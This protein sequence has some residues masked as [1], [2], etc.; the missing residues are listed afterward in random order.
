MRFAWQK[1]QANHV[2]TVNVA[3]TTHLF[4]LVYNLTWLLPIVLTYT[5][6]I[7]YP[8]GFATFAGICFI[9]FLANLYANNVLTAQ[10]F[11]TFL[12]RA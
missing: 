12:L 6:E 10:Q 3:G 9:R 11:D 5:G 2:E 1:K 8:T 4:R 7:D